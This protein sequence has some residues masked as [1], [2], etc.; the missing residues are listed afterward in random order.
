MKKYFNKNLLSYTLGILISTLGIVFCTK[1]DLGLSMI[2]ATPYIFSRFFSE[3]I[4]WITQGRAE[5]IWNLFI[6]LVLAIVVKKWKWSYLLAFVTSFFVGTF[7]DLWLMILGKGIYETLALRVFM[8]VLGACL[9]SLGI[10]FYFRTTYPCQAYELFVKEYADKYK[11]DINKTKKYYDYI[12][13][14]IDVI[15]ALVMF[16]SFVG[17]GLGTVFITILNSRMIALFSKILDKIGY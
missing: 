4:P 9:T 15:L 2:A 1:S 16:K 6:I 3:S 17:V 8:F 5:Y 10:A 11:T 7:I 14:L 13:L 12:T